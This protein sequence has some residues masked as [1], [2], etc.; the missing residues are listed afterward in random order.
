MYDLSHAR[1]YVPIFCLE[2]YVHEYFWTLGTY[3]FPN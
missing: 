3:I 1:K 2:E